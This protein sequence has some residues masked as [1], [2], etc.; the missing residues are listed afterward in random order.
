MGGGDRKKEKWIVNIRGARFGGERESRE[1]KLDIKN[2]RS[3][4][5]TMGS[6]PSLQ[7]QDV[8]SIPSPA[9][10]IKGSAAVP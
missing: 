2:R 9:Q 7:W 3:H 10:W 1:G 6:V 8:D 4:C 5:G